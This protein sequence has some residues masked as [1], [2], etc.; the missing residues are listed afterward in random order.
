MLRRLGD[1]PLG[2]DVS[3]D[4]DEE[5]EDGEVDHDAE[6]V[7]E[8]TYVGHQVGLILDEAVA[9]VGEVVV[10]HLTVAGSSSLVARFLRRLVVSES[11]DR[12]LTGGDAVI[13][14]HG[15]GAVT[16][17]VASLDDVAHTGD[18][19]I[20]VIEGKEAQHIGQLEIE[21]PGVLFRSQHGVGI[22]IGHTDDGERCTLLTALEVLHGGELHRLVLSHLIGGEVTGGDGEHRGDD[23]EGGGELDALERKAIALILQQI[24]ATDTHGDDR[25]EEPAGDDGVEKLCH[26]HGVERHGSEVNHLIA[27]GVGIEVH[28]GRILHPAIGDEDPPCGDGG[29]EDRHPGGE[30]VEAVGDL[31]PAEE[32][33]HEEGRLQEEG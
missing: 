5:E 30:V 12:H 11:L 19:G 25:P 23:A 8:H 18:I 6:G 31:A 15:D 20:E 9:K 13:D 32:H 26:S 4:R 22:L 1:R 10:Q 33:H 17:R 16:L 14:G 29:T 2:E 27:D 7:V 21:V 3:E 28:A 24:V